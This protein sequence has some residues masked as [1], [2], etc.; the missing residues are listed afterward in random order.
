MK[1]IKSIDFWKGLFLGILVYELLK[2]VIAIGVL[3]VV[4]SM[5]GG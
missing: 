4:Y 1:L 5:G 3:I 2:G